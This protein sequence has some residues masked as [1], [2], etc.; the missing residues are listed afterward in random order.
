MTGPMEED[1]DRA[2]EL[3]DPDH[4]IPMNDVDRSAT[5]AEA[6]VTLKLYGA[7]YTEIKNTLHYSSAYRARMA[8]ERALAAAA[9]SVEDKE[10][11]RYLINKTLDRLKASVM[12]KAVNPN[13]PQH[14]AY[15]ARALAI[16]DRQA[17]LYGVDA[18]TQIQITQSDQY[19]QEYLEAVLPGVKEDNNQI[20]AN[21]LEADEAED[22]EIVDEEGNVI[23]QPEA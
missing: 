16:L 6:A 14:L 13:D 5:K 20:E 3:A 12:S 4:G 21:I 23:G 18:P 10:K 9:D 19:I 11:M 7:S 2:I 1:I 15:N 22:A 8:V 17:K